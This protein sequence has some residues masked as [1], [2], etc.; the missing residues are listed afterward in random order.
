MTDF[1]LL[2][3]AARA[4]GLKLSEPHYTDALMVE[5][6]T[7][8]GVGHCTAVVP[9]NPLTDDGDALRLAVALCIQ[10]LLYE[11]SEYVC[12]HTQCSLG[13]GVGGYHTYQDGEYMIEP[14]NGD[15]FS[16]TR[17]AIVRAASEI[18]KGELK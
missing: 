11:E 10:I 14:F 2:V 3:L 12:A 6:V 15:K 4:A 17:R 18:G 13:V 9:W 1:E 8:Q 5:K 16:A 7:G